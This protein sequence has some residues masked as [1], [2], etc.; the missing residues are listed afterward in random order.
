[1]K[2]ML[3]MPGQEE[4]VSVFDKVEIVKMNDNHAGSP[5][6]ITYY[7]TRLNAGKT[8]V[9]LNRD[10]KMVLKL[11]DGRSVDVLLQHSSMDT[12][13]KAIG[14]LRVLSGLND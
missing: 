12:Q 5:Y 1:M 3:Y 4:P 9:E 14:V 11:E 7:S 8:M 13:G 10:V 2:A 6:R